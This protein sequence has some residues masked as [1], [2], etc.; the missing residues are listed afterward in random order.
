LAFN[1]SRRTTICGP[2]GAQKGLEASQASFFSQL[3]SSYSQN[4]GEQ[5][6]IFS[7]LTNALSPILQGGPNQMG[8]SASEN[9]ALTG[10]AINSAAA[11][12]RNAQVIAA[13]SAGGNTG[14]TTG[15]QKQLQAQIA[16][17]V[18]Q[19]LSSNENQINLTN[20]ATGR[21]NFYNAEAGLSGVAG[22]ENPIGYAGQANNA[23]GQAFNEASQIQQMKNQEQADI[24]G[25]TMSLA[26][27]GLSG[28]SAGFGNLDTTGGSS[29]G[30]QMGNFFSGF[31][32]G[33]GG[34][35]G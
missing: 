32:Q 3:Q 4:F 28:A 27:M 29:F 19:N 15:G 5:Q 22:M 20:A 12:N 33:V 18:G 16:S 8:F 35:G 21:S 6:G 24:A 30:E 17:G 34:G 2:S 9:A 7:S 23:G 11:A 25:A 26:T 1:Q 10:G 13:S 14:V 31:G